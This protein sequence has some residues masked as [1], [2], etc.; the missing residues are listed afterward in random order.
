MI[1]EDIREYIGTIVP[2]E[3]IFSNEL[4]R[5][6]TTFRVGGEAELF[7]KISN[8]DQL[9]KLIPFFNRLEIDY[10]ILGNGSNVLVSDNG[11]QG[12]ILQ[13]G[14]H[15][16]EVT[17]NG[18]IITA[19]AG[20]LLSKLAAIA[21]EHGLTGMEFAS[22]I[23]GTVGGG[24]MMNAGAYDGE[25]A[26]I[27]QSVVIMNKAGELMELNHDTME[28]GYRT[29]VVKNRPYIVME[30]T[31]ALTVGNKEDIK[32]KMEQLARQR[33]EKQP[34]EYASAGSTFKRPHGHYAGKLIMDAGLRG[35]SIGGACVSEKHCGFV[36]NRGNA[37]A[38]DILEVIKEI[39][40][41]VYDRFDVTLEPEVICLGDF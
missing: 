2:P 11:Y 32:A 41:R 8:Q 40:D 38:T 3:D 31:L 13:I 30:V 36:V 20:V 39:Q 14:E 25:M 37:T 22:G 17:V 16:S 33:R 18:N 26:Q 10:F 5:G 1:N 34:L 28:F 21:C 35:F 7:I 19:Q 29:S 23:P 24:I 27:T 9:V 12:V 4:L 15:M 6:H